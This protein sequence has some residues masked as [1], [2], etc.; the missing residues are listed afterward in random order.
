M[1]EHKRDI[2]YHI[3]CATGDVG[4]TA[5][6]LVTLVAVRPLPNILT[7]RSM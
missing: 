4:A 6:S 7:G 1:E 3:Q 5:F 2:Q